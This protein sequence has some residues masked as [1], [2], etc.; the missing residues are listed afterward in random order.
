[1]LEKSA[2]VIVAAGTSRRMQ[3]RDK[4]WIPL[5]GR[6]TLA[7][8][9][10]I[11]QSSPLVESIVLVT[12]AERIADVTVL[13]QQEGW[14][15][16]TGVVKGGARRQDSVCAGLD[17]LAAL[18]PSCRWV[19]IHDGARPFV[20][21]D[22]LKAGLKT[23]QE[24]QAAVAAVPVKDTIKQVQHGLITA[25][26]D[27]SHLWAIQTP[28]VFSFPLIHQ[29]HHCPLAQE[30]MTDDATLL[31]RLGHTVAIFPG[32]YT[33]IKITTQEDLIFAEALLRG[34]TL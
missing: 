1:M 13:C 23:A 10:D 5:G 12:S 11:F 14:Q 31:E 18:S 25:T 33:N 6:I 16:V 7:R 21:E 22:I 30:D 20:T 27:R 8:T 3:G 26:P 29:A 15:K 34:Q 2:V 19:M 17:A 24:H 28:Q 9:I 32:L 4:L